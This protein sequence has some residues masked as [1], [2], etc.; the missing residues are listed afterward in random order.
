MRRREIVSSI[1]GISV[2][3][4]AMASMVMNRR[5]GDGKLQFEDMSRE[6]FAAHEHALRSRDELMASEMSGCFHCIAVFA[7]YEIREWIDGGQT[8]M[9]PRC[10][11]DSVIGTRSG[12]PVTTEFLQQMQKAWF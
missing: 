1:L 6:L 3:W 5:F 2:T 4:L 11:V 7:P 9:C 10:G 8:A 12:F